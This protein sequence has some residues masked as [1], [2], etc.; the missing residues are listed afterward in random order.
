MKS[1]FITIFV[2]TILVLSVE[3]GV[4]NVPADQPTIQA[5]I[6]AAANGD[7][8]LV[9]DGTYFENINYNGKAITVSSHYLMDSDTSH[10]SNTIIDGSQPTNPNSGSVV[11]FISGEDTTS[12]LSGFTV[13]GGSGNFGTIPRG[14]GYYPPFNLRGGG[15][16]VSRGAKITNNRIIY[17]KIH[18]DGSP[19]S[20]AGIYAFT[21]N[22]TTQENGNVIIKNNFIANNKASGTYGTNGAGML[23]EG[24][25]Y[26]LISKNTIKNNRVEV[27]DP[28]ETTSGGGGIYIFGTAILIKNV[29]VGNEAP[30]GGGIAARGYHVGFNIRLVNNTI[31][32]NNAS[33]KGG[34]IYLSNGHCSAINNIFW[35]NT[36]P[37]DPDIFYR[38]NLDMSY[39]ITQG[40]IPG[41][42]NLQ[43]DPLFE[44]SEYHLSDASPAIDAGNPD[45]KF[46]DTVDPGN[47]S[48][49]LWPAKGSL[50]ADMG[51]FGGN[52]TVHVEIED[53]L[54]QKNFLYKQ[55]GSLDYRLAY[56]LNYDSTSTYPL[57][58]VFHG[59]A[60]YDG[61]ELYAGLQWRINAEHYD[62][63]EFTILPLWNVRST[64]LD[65]DRAHD[66]IWDIIGNYPIDTTKIVITGHSR[67]GGAVKE[68]LKLDPQLFSAAVPVSAVSRSFLPKIKHVP[69]WVNHGSTD[70]LN[71]SISRDYIAAFE[72]TGLTALYAE[73]SSAVQMSAAINNNARLFYSE[74]VGAGHVIARHTYDNK[75]LFEWIKKQSRPLIRPQNSAVNKRFLSVNEDS[76]LFTTTFS[77]P[78][79]FQ[80]QPTLIVENFDKE[81]LRE[82]SLFDD[83]LHGD[84]LAQDGIWGNISSFQ[85]DTY[86]LGVHVNNLDK[87]HE[88]Y[89]HDLAVFTTNGPVTFE[90]YE[91]TSPD[92]VP[93]PGDSFKLNIFLKN[94]GETA[95][96]S[97]I[98]TRLTQIDPCAEL[99]FFGST[100]DGLD[101]G[102][103]KA[104]NRTF[105]IKI[106][107]DCS[108]STI[109]V[110]VDIYLHDY[111]F[112][113]DTLYIDV[114]T[115]VAA[116]EPVKPEK[117]ALQ[118]NYPN[119]FNPETSI[120]FTVPKM[121]RVTLAI[122]D[123]LGRKIRTLV[124]ETKAAGSYN[125]T[126]NGK[127]NQG[128]PLASGLYF[129]KLQAGEF[130]ATKKMMLLK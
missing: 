17:N 57:T 95:S 28:I 30:N 91:I 40:I 25:G 61:T 118:Q 15:V 73:D 55:F 33:L 109:P 45:P 100:I 19:V 52:D 70:N 74:F 114:V 67:G 34:G 87:E 37:T 11:S 44:D 71:A 13:T 50:I 39:C 8:V 2:I 80:Y 101:P 18:R 108:A 21:G 58:I 9:A 106:D 130:S 77:N 20:G 86:R 128:Q 38:G 107:G 36:A 41:A 90:Y 83:G 93:N 46:N 31:A 94:N 126:W 112:W 23:V 64:D 75:F 63:N 68:L 102:E 98:E 42:G 105:S 5:G 78:H 92:T 10:I 6:D 47:P 65:R 66:L 4:I 35:A 117:F 123:I 110:Q 125:V 12:V 99:R 32:D 121:S 103:T 43:T 29:I 24:I 124:S 129:Y 85:E 72:N 104:H 122:Y 82:I 119:P 81:K 116:S 56:P 54:V 89:F 115:S 62:Y 59:A 127:N 16:L 48:I 111:L 88:F 49:P 53:Y 1:Y 22:S 14:E 69:V 26:T 27:D 79:D 3:A 7:T 84:S 96:I 113:V 97:G 120:H 51:A 60:I 76:V